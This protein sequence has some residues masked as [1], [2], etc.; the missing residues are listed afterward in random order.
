MAKPSPGNR[1]QEAERGDRIGAREVM[2]D[3][4]RIVVV[5]RR[6]R[7]GGDEVLGAVTVDTEVAVL[8]AVVGPTEELT[9]GDIEA[10]EA[11]AAATFFSDIYRGNPDGSRPA[12][13]NCSYS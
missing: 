10:L 1:Q 7:C 12:G 8:V 2:G 13:C 9:R 3:D 11:A 4:C 5:F 6:R